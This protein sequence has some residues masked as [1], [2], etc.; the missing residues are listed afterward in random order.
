M[1]HNKVDSLH[2]QL[3]RAYDSENNPIWSALIS[4]IGNSDQD[5]AELIENVRK[6]FFI[7]T[8]TRPYIDRL[9]TRDNVQRPRFIGM[10][11]PDFRKFIPIM[12]YQP[13]QVKLIFDKLLDLF[14]LKDATTS[15]IQTT[16]Y[17]PFILEDEWSLEYEVD[18]YN[19]ERIEFS[20]NE[21][22]DI[23]NA[24]ADEVVAAI[25]R[26]TRYS[27]AVA[28]DDSLTKRT[29]IRIFTNTIGS[30]GSITQTGG[31]ANIGLRFDGFNELAGTGS[32]TVWNVTKVGETTTFTYSSG[33]DPNLSHIQVGDIVL[34]NLPSNLGTFEITNVDLS[35]NA[36]SFNN[37]FATVGVETQTSNTDLRF[38]QAY[39]ANIWRQSRRALTWEVSPGEIIVELPPS[40]PIVKRNRKG[41]AHING[42]IS[43]MTVRDSDTSLTIDDASNFPD[44]GQFMM[45]MEQRVIME[46]AD[47]SIS[48]H[49]FF[50]RLIGNQ[51]KYSYTSKS[52][53]TLL[54]ITP[55]L[56]EL[57]DLNKV[58]LVS[59]TR[60]SHDLTVVS[61]TAHGLS[62]DEYA[63]IEGTIGAL[64]VSANGTWKVTEII[65]PTSFV[66]RSPGD[67]GSVTGGTSR[68]ERIG[69]K[70]AGTKIISR[71]STLKPDT[72]GPYLWDTNAA[73]VLSSYTTNLTT[74]IQ[75]G[76]TVRNIQVDANDIPDEEGRLIF[77][78][79]TEREEGP[80]RYFFKP[81]DTVI[82]IDPAYIFNYNHPINDSVTMIRRRGGIQFGGLGTE[83]APY[84]TDPAAAREVLQELMEEIKSVG[85]F[86]NFLVRYPT[87]Y[88]ATVDVYRSGVDPED[89][90][91]E[92]S[93][94][95]S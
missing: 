25:N 15:F 8:A 56:P 4:A 88:Y 24:T 3:P 7:K 59:A 55:N 93:N 5:I 77:G 23:G 61:S 45:E 78:F 67:D 26:Q 22:V 95:N 75:A 47:T 33:I 54:G 74:A 43:L 68:I 81:S 14:F 83:R 76:V 64:I 92:A 37:V 94:R 50:S 62:V 11:D 49:D 6:Q 30:K 35:N 18:K 10:D 66:C 65:S 80:V 19:N 91:W 42:E 44:S 20:T 16:A 41:A 32:N 38:M 89:T 12:S 28:Y 57:A 86:L 48:N 82:S 40:P 46:L 53:N 36:F 87:Q 72:E 60:L 13:K 39:T 1:A 17:E 29:H 84:I 73:Y 69:L 70:V 34:I 58:N 31:L 51:Q 2:K 21:F 71:T 79:G 9:G 85:I 63:I 52:G 90:Y 27:Y